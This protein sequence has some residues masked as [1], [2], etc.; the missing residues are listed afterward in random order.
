MEKPIK[1]NKW[2]E[3]VLNTYNLDDNIKQTEKWG[4][5]HDLLTIWIQKDSI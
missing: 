1:L 5:L 4:I 2:L 3:N